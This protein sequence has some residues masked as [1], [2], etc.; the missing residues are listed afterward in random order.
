[1]ICSYHPNNHGYPQLSVLNGKRLI[2]RIMYELAHGRLAPGMCVLHT[3]DTPAC[4]NPEHLFAG[5]KR[6]NTRDMVRKG[7]VVL[8]RFGI[9]PE[10]VIARVRL[11]RRLVASGLLYDVIARQTGVAESCVSGIARG[12]SWSEIPWLPEEINPR[13]RQGNKKRGE[14]NARAKATE[15]QVRTIRRRLAAEPKLKRAKLAREMSLA[16]HVVRSIARGETWTHV[17][18]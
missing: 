12:E 13:A 10:A 11:I 16:V 5:T 18:A 8:A 14:N 15:E 6:D 4:V 17:A 3:C 7:R 1:L 2:S 9:A